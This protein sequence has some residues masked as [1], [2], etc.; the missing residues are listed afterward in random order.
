[1]ALRRNPGRAAREGDILDVGR[2]CV[3]TAEAQSIRKLAGIAATS[4]PD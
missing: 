4:A 2:R 1:M 3:S